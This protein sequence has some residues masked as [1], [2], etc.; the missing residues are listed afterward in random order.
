MTD[1]D[2]SLSSAPEYALNN[3]SET[4]SPLLTCHI[5]GQMR[6]V[7]DKAEDILNAYLLS[8]TTSWTLFCAMT[9]WTK[10]KI[11]YISVSI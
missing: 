3:F 6:H 10:F 2:A 8:A 4:L 9:S 5:G 11:F 1:C 7:V